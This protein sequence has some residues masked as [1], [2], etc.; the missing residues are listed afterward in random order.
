MGF[1][2]R[3]NTLLKPGHQPQSGTSY[4]HGLTDTESREIYEYLVRRTM[5]CFSAYQIQFRLKTN[6][7]QV[8][9]YTLVRYIIMCTCQPI[10]GYFD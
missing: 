8:V 7:Q 3:V 6:V 2:M 5:V 1:V 10:L 4:P 9:I